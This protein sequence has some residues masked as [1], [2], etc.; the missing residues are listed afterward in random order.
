VIV[1][2]ARRWAGRDGSRDGMSVAASY[3]AW[4]LAEMGRQVRCLIPAGKPLP[5]SHDLVDWAELRPEPRPEELRGDLIITT[6]APTWR[7]VVVA[8]QRAGCLERLVYWHHHGPVP[9]GYGCVLARVAPGSPAPGWSR[10]LVLPPASWA[11]YEGGEPTGQA[12]VVPGVSRAKGGDIAVA[13]ARLVSDLP[14]YVLPGRATEQELA[15]WRALP[16]A[17][18]AL[19]GLPPAVWL[20]EARAVF[21]PT[22]AE[23]YG[24]AMAEAAARGVPIVTSDLPGPRFAL[25]D[26]VRALRPNATPAEWAAALYAALNQEPRRLQPQPYPEVVAGA[27]DPLVGTLPATPP[28]P[29]VVRP[30]RPHR[31]ATVPKVAVPIGETSIMAALAS[32]PRR[33]RSLQ[34]VVEALLPQVD[35]LGVY[36]NEWPE[37]P[38]FLV[39]PKILVARSQEFWDKGDAGKM[40]WAGQAG[41]YYLSCDDDILYPADYVARTVEGIERYE[42]RAVVTWHGFRYRLPYAGHQQ[43]DLYQYMHALPADLRCHGAGT[44]VAGWH[45]S[46]GITPDDFPHPNMADSWLAVWA[47]QRQVPVMGLA[48]PAG[49]IEPLPEARQHA[50]YQALG[51]GHGPRDTLALRTWVEQTRCPWPDL[52]A[53]EASDG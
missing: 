48:H 39:H 52:E 31:R 11:L 20:A 10:E 27:L 21:S 26:V 29:E 49:W 36:L 6:I 53:A 16:H 30:A 41:G 46:L 15:P 40:H 44:G 22:R 23:T 7:R 42:R 45:A 5:W 47:N 43:R 51:R 4:T 50:I 28:T 19:P 14:W 38:A 37:V 1:I 25:G 9:P 2:L 18:V 34:L 17:T 32:V 13:V 12:I 3:L 8:T 24:L 35:I 33:E